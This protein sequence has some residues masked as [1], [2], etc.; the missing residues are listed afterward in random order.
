[1]QFSVA[2]HRNQLHEP[3]EPTP[4][5]PSIN[6]SHE[7]ESSQNSASQPAELPTRWEA[8][9]IF[10]L[11]QGN[12]PYLQGSPG[13]YSL[14][15]HPAENLARAATSTEHQQ[16][17]KKDAEIHVT[18]I[19][20]KQPATLHHARKP[21]PEE[22]ILPWFFGL[23]ARDILEGRLK[24]EDLGLSLER[25]A[26]IRNQIRLALEMSLTKYPDTR[27]SW[28][29]NRWRR[30]HHWANQEL[31]TVL[32]PAA[33]ETIWSFTRPLKFQT[34]RDLIE[35]RQQYEAAVAAVGESQRESENA[36][37]K[38]RTLF[39]A[40]IDV[41]IELDENGG[42]QTEFLPPLKELFSQPEMR[43]DYIIFSIHPGSIGVP[44]EI[45][46][47]PDKLTYAHLKLFNQVRQELT[48]LSTNNPTRHDLPVIWGHPF[49]EK[50]TADK[51]SFGMPGFAKMS[52]A[53]QQKLVQAAVDN[54]IVIE[55]NLVDHRLYTHDTQ[56]GPRRRTIAELKN[57][58]EMLERVPILRAPFWN[59][60]IEAGAKVSLDTDL[61]VLDWRNCPKLSAEPLSLLHM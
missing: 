3:S 27:D 22:K 28:Q 43:L 49:W 16:A 19:G 46:D 51:P 4:D 29:S 50:P 57:P 30:Y 44:K 21:Y 13:W 20:V 10:D 54:N 9:D 31:K 23:T 37:E 48:E 32:D 34:N 33:Y 52:A 55:I 18:R 25:F 45:T 5:Q 41:S 61:H 24:A 35:A 53:Q 26:E 56:G 7:A 6:S 15:H 38:A 58:D 2:R 59:Y 17:V 11:L 14:H 39:G 36:K 47:D 42:I 12:S 40:E 1:M 8:H 60:I